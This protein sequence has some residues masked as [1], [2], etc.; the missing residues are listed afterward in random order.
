MLRISCSPQLC[1][2]ASCLLTQMKKRDVGLSGIFVETK[3]MKHVISLGCVCTVSVSC[4]TSAALCTHYQSPYWEF[5]VTI[6]EI[7][8]ADLLL[9]ELPTHL[10]P[11]PN[12]LE[13]FLRKT[14]HTLP[15]LPQNSP[16]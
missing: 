15:T 8:P 16:V 11:F 2:H 12:A 1:F 13:L 6:T 10:A 5:L 9:L 14:W 3:F 7:C 4:D